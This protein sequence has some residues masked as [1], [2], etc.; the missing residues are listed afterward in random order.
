M[1]RILAAADI[2]LI[3]VV[4]G[5]IAIMDCPDSP[6]A[7]VCF[8]GAPSEIPYLATIHAASDAMTGI[9][10]PADI[11][12]DFYGFWALVS[13]HDPYAILGP[14]LKNIGVD[15]PVDSPSA[16]PPTSFLLVAPVAWLP[17]PRSFLA[18]SWA[19]I[20][21]LL[22]CFHASGFSWKTSLLLMALALLWPP[23][24]W[25]LYQTTIVWVLGVMLAYQFH[26]SRPI[27]AGAFIALASFTK[28]LPAILLMPLIVRRGWKAPLGFLLSWLC[29]LATI[30]ILD[31][32]AISR[33]IQVN[34]ANYSRHF[35]RG[36]NAS[37]L[38]LILAGRLSALEIALVVIL[39]VMLVIAAATLFKRAWSGAPI[40]FA[41]W[42]FFSYLSVALLPI[43]WSFAIL[44][45]LPLL[46]QALTRKNPGTLLAA[47]SLIL[48]VPFS[49]FGGDVRY[50]LLPTLVLSGSAIALNAITES[51]APSPGWSPRRS[52]S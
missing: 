47:A 4:G 34:P 15:W 21:A 48:A 7:F 44:P 31:P 20:G 23:T 24:I 9:S 40:T 12:Q 41:E 17:W 52:L 10:R 22:L 51:T 6:R 30:Q 29:A 37:P 27:L 42:A 33:F 16:H 26:S 13:G 14:A 38:A 50:W 3:I 35:L 2:I 32:R 18:W 25:G 43:L 11:A 49:A 19:M 46:V 36:D 8:R 5:R 45:L 39:A 1:K 28:F